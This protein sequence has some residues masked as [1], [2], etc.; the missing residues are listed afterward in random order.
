M[1]KELTKVVMSIVVLTALFTLNAKAG[2][3]Y[4]NQLDADEDDWVAEFICEELQMA[5]RYVNYLYE[6]ML[7]SGCNIELDAIGSC[8][9]SDPVI[10][11]F[12]DLLLDNLKYQ[13]VITH[14]DVAGIGID[15]VRF[16]L[17]KAKGLL[18]YSMAFICESQT[19]SI[20]FVSSLD[21]DLLSYNNGPNFDI[22]CSDKL[23]AVLFQASKRVNGYYTNLKRQGCAQ[24]IQMIVGCPVSEPSVKHVYDA[25]VD[26]LIHQTILDPMLVARLNCLS[27]EDIILHAQYLVIQALDD[28]CSDYMN[29]SN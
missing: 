12:Y 5:S 9:D 27:G 15:N 14:D 3:L 18:C 11:K 24:P 6:D 23:Y 22:D 29:A 16:K 25:L 26:Q 10:I 1:K 28:M 4:V 8:P 20:D 2:N 19:P 21:N 13:T 17:S 7:Q